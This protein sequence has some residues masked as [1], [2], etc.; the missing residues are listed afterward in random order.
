MSDTAVMSDTSGDTIAGLASHII[1]ITT[2]NIISNTT[3]HNISKPL[4]R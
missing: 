2:N 4:V 1:R 3:S